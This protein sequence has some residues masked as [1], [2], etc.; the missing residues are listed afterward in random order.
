MLPTPVA[1]PAAASLNPAREQEAAELAP[2]AY[3]RISP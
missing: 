1:P 2:D 3:G